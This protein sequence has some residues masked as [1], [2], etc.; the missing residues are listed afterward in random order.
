MTMT[1]L[2]ALRNAATQIVLPLAIV[3]A[4]VPTSAGAEEPA[5]GSKEWWVEFNIN[6]AAADAALEKVMLQRAMAQAMKDYGESEF[7]KAL[8]TFLQVQ[9]GTGF[10]ATTAQFLLGQMHQSGYGVVANETEA[11]RYYKLAAAGGWPDANYNLGNIYYNNLD[12]IEARRAFIAFTKSPE[13]D[14]ISKANAQYMLGM[15]FQRGDGVAKDDALSSSYFIT[16]SILGGGHNGARYEL[17]MDY[18]KGD[19]VDQ[20]FARAAEY[21]QKASHYNEVSKQPGNPDAQYALSTLYSAGKGVVQSDAEA[22]KYLRMAAR[23]DHTKAQFGMGVL[24]AT[25]RGVPQSMEIAYLWI[26]RAAEGDAL[27]RSYSATT[28]TALAYTNGV[29]EAIDARDK[30]RANLTPELIAEGQILVD[31]CVD[32]FAACNWG[33]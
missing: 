31:R 14:E 9:S 29:A 27:F 7:A 32:Y 24:Y 4:L 23:D 11:I 1:L 28:Q 15:L 26:A 18:L 17:G 21:F 5:V 13:A 19:G 30:I 20:N 8:P 2:Y 33:E 10:D 3:A 12:F 6:R 22:V 16:A 25:G